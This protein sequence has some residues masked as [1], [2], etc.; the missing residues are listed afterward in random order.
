MNKG[1]TNAVKQVESFMRIQ[2]FL[3][4]GDSLGEFHGWPISPDIGL[5]LLE[6][7]R[8]QHYDLI[9]EFGSGTS[10][11]LFARAIEVMQQQAAAKATDQTASPAVTTFVSFEHDTFYLG[12]T[13]QMLK[14]RGLQK[15]VRLVHAPLVEWLDGDQAYLYYD[16]K[17]TLS[18][19]AQQNIDRQLR[20]LVFVDGPPGVTCLNARYPAA[21]Y[22][23]NALS[24][25][26]IDFVLDDAGRPEEKQ[27][28]ELWRTFWKKRSLRFEDYLISSEKG[29]YCGVLI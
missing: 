10:T 5:F 17:A 6:R 21:P 8:E 15:Q 20:I 7:M 23:L 14:A 26:Q 24:R 11:A 4:D 27:V 16:C 22:V 19:I 13:Q 25:H 3:G 29:I 12:K 28:I 2:S 18:E 9:I 1:L